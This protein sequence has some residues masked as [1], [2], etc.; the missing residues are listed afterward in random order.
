MKELARL[1]KTVRVRVEKL[2]FGNE[3]KKDPFLGGKVG[4]MVGY[5]TY[6]K[7]RVGD[8]RVGVQIERQRR[9]V[10]FMRVL[11]RKEIYG[12]FS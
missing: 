6:Y 9:T 4:K 7:I 1:P 12:K 5:K 10:K 8:Y 3:I 2:V 11:H